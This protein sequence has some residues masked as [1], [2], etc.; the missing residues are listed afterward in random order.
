[1]DVFFTHKWTWAP[2]GTFGPTEYRLWCNSNNLGCLKQMT[3]GLVGFGAKTASNAGDQLAQLYGYLN[4][5]L[6][7]I[8]GNS[9]RFGTKH[10]QLLL[11]VKLIRRLRLQYYVLA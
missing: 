4:Q 5:C 6:N 9:S 2:E 10:S 8:L 3:W 1:M 7:F 11:L